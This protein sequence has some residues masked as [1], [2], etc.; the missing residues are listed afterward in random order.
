MRSV[1]HD[2]TWKLLLKRLIHIIRSVIVPVLRLAFRWTGVYRMFLIQ[3]SPLL[4]RPHHTQCLALTAPPYPIMETN[5]QAKKALGLE[6]RMIG[7]GTSIIC[8]STMQH[9]GARRFFVTVANTRIEVSARRC[10]SSITCS[11]WRWLR[12]KLSA[13]IGAWSCTALG[14]ALPVLSR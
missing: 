2:N 3:G 14:R 6:K 13:L 1:Y 9:L 10:G 8:C 11:I 7:C 5:N 12:R 4:Y